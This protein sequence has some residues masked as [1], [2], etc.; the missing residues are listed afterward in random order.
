M[1]AKF[2]GLRACI[3]QAMSCFLQRAQVAA[4]LECHLNTRSRVSKFGVVEMLTI[5]D[6]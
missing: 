4:A 5:L 2:L 6:R 3:K 1:Y